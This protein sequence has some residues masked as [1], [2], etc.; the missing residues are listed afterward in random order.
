MSVEGRIFVWK[1]SEGSK[2]ED[3]PQ[4]TGK[5][6]TAVQISGE[7]ESARPRVCWHCHKQVMF[8]LLLISTRS[9]FIL[10]MFICGLFT[11]FV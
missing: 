1:I 7:T 5:V 3:K 8:F 11:P 2:E 6:V 9:C 10:L 4:I